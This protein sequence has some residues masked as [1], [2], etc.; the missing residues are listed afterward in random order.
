MCC[1]A[2]T[3]RVCRNFLEQTARLRNECTEW[4]K[5]ISVTW[6]TKYIV[7]WR[8]KGEIM[9]PEEMSI[10]GPPCSGTWPYRLGESRVWDSKIC[11]WVRRD[12]NLRMT[13]LVRIRSNCKPQTHPLVREGTPHRQTRNC[14]TLTKIWSWTSG[15]AWHQDRLAYWLSVVTTLTLTVTFGSPDCEWVCRQSILISGGQ[16]LQPWRVDLWERLQPASR[17]IYSAGSRYQ[18][19]H[20]EDTADWWIVECVK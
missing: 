7:T 13:A 8:L 10:A 1:G 3:R 17:G 15:E 6:T 5:Y 14:L 11:S 19:A 16:G 2:N 4:C 18:A 20:S 9:E 12:S